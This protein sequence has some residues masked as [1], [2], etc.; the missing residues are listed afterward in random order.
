M[1]KVRRPSVAWDA[2]HFVET[3]GRHT[4]VRG[5]VHSTECGDAPGVTEEKGVVGYWDRQNAGYGAQVMIDSDASTALCADMDRITWH[6]LG[7]NTGSIGVELVGFAKFSLKTWFVRI[8]QLRELAK[9]I[10]YLNLEYGIPM[11]F[12]TEVGWSR[13]ADQ[14][15]KYGGD[16]TDP[17]KGFPLGFVLTLARRYRRR[18]W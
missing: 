15:K 8:K 12:S 1:A 11:V 17:G 7:R 10:A 3:H 4:P 6:T 18:G 9:W 2:R 13:H 14:S 16:H 5:I